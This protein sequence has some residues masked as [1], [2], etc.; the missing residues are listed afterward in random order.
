MLRGKS[1][2]ANMIAVAAN[3]Y[4]KVEN[5]FRIIICNFLNNFI[6]R[7]EAGNKPTSSKMEM[8]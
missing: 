3:V 6:K 7:N 2:T 1:A 8:F 4:D 5:Y